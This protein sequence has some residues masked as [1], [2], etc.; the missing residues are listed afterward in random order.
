MVNGMNEDIKKEVN[1]IYG[2]VRGF[3]WGGINELS[4][5]EWVRFV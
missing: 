3:Y 5:E 1:Y 2:G 4:F